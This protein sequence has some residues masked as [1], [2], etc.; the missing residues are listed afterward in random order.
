ME[1][2]RATKPED[3]ILTDEQEESYKRLVEA[4]GVKALTLI[5]LK[6]YKDFLINIEA[7]KKEAVEEYK[8]SLNKQV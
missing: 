6:H 3:I 5:H 7:I 4:I 8:A 2:P 1:L